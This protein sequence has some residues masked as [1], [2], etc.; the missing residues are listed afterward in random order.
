M[1][2]GIGNAYEY[3]VRAGN[4]LANWATFPLLIFQAPLG[5]LVESYRATRCRR[6]EKK[7][8]K[9]VDIT[10]TGTHF[11][12]PFGGVAFPAAEGSKIEKERRM[13]EKSPE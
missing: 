9:P 1:H 2:T 7:P 3:P 10:N 13:T 6:R 4:V 12:S 11:E 5:I 8:K